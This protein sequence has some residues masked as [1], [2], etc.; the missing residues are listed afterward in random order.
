VVQGEWFRV[1]MGAKV[2]FVT[3]ERSSLQE[4]RTRQT[5]HI[6]IISRSR[7]IHRIQWSRPDIGQSEISEVLR[8]MRTGWLSQGRVTEQFEQRLAEYSGAKHAIAVNNG[9]SALLCA[10]MAHGAGP[11]DRV[12]VSD[13]THVAT[14]NVPRLLGCRVSLVDINPSTFNADY[15][16]LE[17]A[18]KRHRPK[19]VVIVD[20]AGL[21]NDMD[22]LPELAGEHG[23]TL[24]EDAAES[25]GAEYQHHKVGSFGHTT[26]LSFHA[27]KQLTTIEGGAV[28]TSDAQVASRCR[29]LRNHGEPV[30]RKYVS[31]MVGMNLRTTDLQSALGL[32]QLR[33]LDHY[34]LRRNEIAMCYRQ[35][36]PSLF[37][38]QVVPKCV[39]R[40][41]YMM[42]IAVARS[43]ATRDKLKRHLE[44]HGIETRT[45]WPPLHQQPRFRAK[46]TKF[47]ESTRLFAKSISLPLHNA[48]RESEVEEV[49]SEVLS[50]AS[51]SKT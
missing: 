47:P 20:V 44:R 26:T 41:A 22:R 16:A 5:R 9:S 43:R 34:I 29:L 40:H 1:G 33:K 46:N 25:I 49:I 14:G 24:I 39:T 13:Y 36:L 19:F 7:A 42:F 10:L 15:D 17:K 12:I 27:A 3:S 4:S 30:G 32:I 23:F 35:R 18:I 6:S 31:L 45:P 11:G 51:R 38:F 37:R 21:P 50:F 2:L 28:L 8:V 48:M